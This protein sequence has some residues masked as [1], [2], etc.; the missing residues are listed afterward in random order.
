MSNKLQNLNV[1]AALEVFPE[2]TGKVLDEV[3]SDIVSLLGNESKNM[4]SVVSDW[5][6]SDKGI[7][8]TKEGYKLPLPLNNSA[9]VLL[10]FAMQLT[11]IAKNGNFTV[12][13]SV[14]KACTAWFEQK[15]IRIA[16]SAAPVAA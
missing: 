8:S 7:L 14:P 11:K 3:V 15:S 13:A 9:T 2:I 5:T 6:I 10:K 12:D 16:K 1:R 4:T